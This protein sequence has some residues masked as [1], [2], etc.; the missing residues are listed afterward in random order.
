MENRFLR[1]FYIY[2]NRHF[3]SI[4]VSLFLFTLLSFNSISSAS[5]TDCITMQDGS[6]FTGTILPSTVKFKTKYG[7]IEVNTENIVS[8]SMGTLVLKDQSKIIGNFSSGSITIETSNKK[9]DFPATEVIGLTTKLASMRDEKLSTTI[10]NQSLSSSMKLNREDAKRILISKDFNISKAW[11][12]D[13]PDGYFYTPGTKFVPVPKSGMPFSH[14]GIS[15]QVRSYWSCLATKNLVTVIKKKKS[16]PSNIYYEMLEELSNDTEGKIVLTEA[17]QKY[18]TKDLNFEFKVIVNEITGIQ[19]VDK[20]AI[21]AKVFFNGTVESKDNPFNQC[22]ESCWD[23]QSLLNEPYALFELFDDGW[24]FNG[25]NIVESLR[26]AT[27]DSEDRKTRSK[28]SFNLE[29]KEPKFQ[30]VSYVKDKNHQHILETTVGKRQSVPDSDYTVTIKDYIPDAELKQEPINKSDEP[31]NPAIFV[32][33]FSSEK[34]T[35]EGWLIAKDRNYYEDRKQNLLIKYIWLSTEQ[36]LDK[37]LNSVETAKAQLSVSMSGQTQDYPLYLNKVFKFEGTGYTVKMLQYVHNYG[38]GRPLGE[39]PP[40]NPAVQVEI[41]GPEG[42]ETRWVFEKFPDWYKMHPAKYKNVKITCSGIADTYMAKNMVRIYQTPE[43]K[44]MLVYIKD[45]QIAETVPWELEKKYTIPDTGNQVMVASYFPSFDFKREV[46]KKS[47]EVRAPAILAEVEGPSGK[48]EDWI[49]S[50]NQYATWYPDNNFALVYERTEK[51]AKQTSEEK[52][53]PT[54]ESDKELTSKE[55][56]QQEREETNAIE[57]AKKQQIPSLQEEGSN[58]LKNQNCNAAVQAYK[59]LLEIAPENYDA[60]TNIGTAY[61][62]LNE[63]DLSIKHLTKAQQLKPAEYQPYYLMGVAYARKGDKDRAI[64]SLRDAINRRHE[65]LSVSDLEKDANLPEDFKQDQRF[66]GLLAKLTFKKLIS[67]VKD[68]YLFDTHSPTI[69]YKYDN[70]W[71][72]VNY[73]LKDQDEKIIQSDK[74]TG[75]V[76]TDTCRW[77]MNRKYYKYYILV[78]RENDISSKLNLKLLAHDSVW[79]KNLKKS[80]LEP[81]NK[82]HVNKKV[83][84]FLESVKKRLE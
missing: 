26:K 48:V 18:L 84:I 11:Y 59:K 68:V 13:Y 46:I 53:T 52:K 66:K 34:T 16:K 73:T 57:E 69:P 25:W 79:N 78:E 35:A 61:T 6:V 20:T 33:L 77:A 22:F 12:I 32:K 3:W 65:D 39:Q 58:A 45:K 5:T 62:M 17:G 40:D 21:V 55:A 24:R 1:I 36:E 71:D 41:N 82:S 23:I 60:N 30:L 64:D 76:V 63:F 44:Q 15:E 9:L 54:N 80:F 10:Q 51:D 37:A 81:M 19:Y 47:D 83:E 74:E 4:V 56:L 50:S 28:E 70:V 72:A 75:I 43:G 14:D 29:K 38:D 49:F 27:H 8:F 42:T 7:E 2:S 31:N 67:G